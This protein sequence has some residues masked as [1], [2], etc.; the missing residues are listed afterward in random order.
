MPPFEMPA[1]GTRVFLKG[2]WDKKLPFRRGDNESESDFL[3]RINDAAAAHIEK[4]QQARSLCGCCVPCPP[5]PEPGP[6]SVPCR[7]RRRPRRMPRCL[8]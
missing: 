8:S 3:K 6:V 4:K 1:Q 5:R 7:H 2:P